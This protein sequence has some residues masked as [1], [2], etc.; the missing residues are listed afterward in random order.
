MNL[1]STHSV[2]IVTALIRFQVRV[3]SQIPH[4]YCLAMLKIRSF[5]AAD[6]TQIAQLFHETVREINCR[7]YSSQQVKA[8]APD[9]LN[10]RN[11]SEICSQRSTY[12]AEMADTI[13]G[14]AELETNGHIDCFY[15][16]KSYQRCGVG[17]QLYQA[18]ETEARMLKLPHLFTEASITA[19]P[20]FQRLGFAIVREQQVICRGETFTNYAMQKAL[21]PAQPS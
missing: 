3:S 9:D 18:I 2:T 17:T 20:F 21:N 7:D 12:V 5:V 8:W 4:F 13:V 16:H 6:A 1:F 14:F 11:W 19:Q 10:F 15:C